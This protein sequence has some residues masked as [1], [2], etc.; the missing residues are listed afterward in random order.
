MKL[1]RMICA[2]LALLMCFASVAL[3]ETTP[4]D[5]AQEPSMFPLDMEAM[6]GTKNYTFSCTLEELETQGV[7][8]TDEELESGYW[9]HANNGRAYFQVL[10]MGTRGDE[11]ELSVCGAKFAPDGTQVFTLPG[12]IVV[13]ES[14]RADCVEVYGKP[15]YDT[16][17]YVR[18]NLARGKVVYSIEFDEN[19]IVESFSMQ[20]YGPYA[21]GFE[22]DGQAGVEQ[23]NLPDV[24]E[25]AFDEYI[26]DGKMYKGQITLADLE[27]NG[28]VLDHTADLQSQIDAQGDAFVITNPLLVC[29]NGISTLQ[30]LPINRSTD[31]T[32]ALEDCGV[33]YFGV[34][35]TDNVS[36]VLA[37]GITL[38]CDYDDVVA[39]FGEAISEEA[40]ED[41][42][43]TYYEHR[44]L[45]SMVY[46]FSVYDG[47]V[48]YIRVKA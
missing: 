6:I 16:E 3:A 31:N 44:V 11:T 4:S 41:E 48:M 5:A 26:L 29:S 42:G 18:Y 21:W 46:G 28:W 14:N 47:V 40:H 15:S 1:N 39:L 36:I 37:D 32:C 10:L 34:N 38:G 24:K 2:V 30:V 9:H 25:M 33:L 17:S 23:A 7:T 45:G 12:G 8:I 35:V 13:G 27:K 19:G 22:F 43:Y 20:S